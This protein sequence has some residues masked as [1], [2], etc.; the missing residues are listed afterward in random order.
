MS[1]PDMLVRVRRHVSIDVEYEDE[2]NVT[3]VLKRVDQVRW[4]LAG[5]ASAVTGPRASQALSELLQHEL[6]HLDGITSFDRADGPRAVVHRSAYRR[7]RRTLDE[8]VDYVPAGKPRRDRS[9]SS[10]DGDA[11]SAGKRADQRDV[12]APPRSPATATESS[13]TTPAPAAQEPAEAA[14]DAPRPDAA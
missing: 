4:A 14:A 10:A 13:Q 6:D 12:A 11:A 2:A 9:D 8:T 1:F 5:D 3:H 7:H